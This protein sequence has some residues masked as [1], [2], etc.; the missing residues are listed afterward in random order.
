MKLK[1]KRLVSESKVPTR[2]HSTDAGYDLYA[3]I[4]YDLRP[5]DRIQIRTGIALEIPTG[6]VGHVWDKSGLSQKFGLKTLGGVVDSGYRGEIMVGLV[7]LGDIGYE[8]QPGDKIAQLVIQKYEAPEIVEVEK[9][10][11]A[12]RGDA[13]FGSTGN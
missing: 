7:N 2:A 4:G 5:G 6:H 10:E 13:G 1:V 3:A 12:D 9:L 11:A 8:I